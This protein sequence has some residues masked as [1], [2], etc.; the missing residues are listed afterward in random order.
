[1]WRIADFNFA[2]ARNGYSAFAWVLLLAGGLASMAIAE[3]YG[4]MAEEHESLMRQAGRL[5]RKLT[6]PV[7]KRAATAQ[8][9]ALEERHE[10]VPFPWDIVLREIEIAVDPRVALLSL[11]T[12]MTT[13]RTRLVAEARTIDDALGFA[14]RLRDTPVARRV[15]LLAHETKKTPA[16][17]VIG[18]T[19]QIDWDLE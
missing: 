6:P 11:D 4:A 3:R 13:A 12:D 10:T 14:A 17:T 1:M 7:A 5:E 16:G 15:L 9:S 18:F 8:K 19:L 2:V